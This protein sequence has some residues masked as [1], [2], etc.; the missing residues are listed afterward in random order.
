MSYVLNTKYPQRFSA[1]S[2][3]IITKYWEKTNLHNLTSRTLNFASPKWDRTRCPEKEASLVGLSDPL[4]N[5]KYIL[6][7]ETIKEANK[8]PDLLFEFV[9]FPNNQDTSA[10]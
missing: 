6:R 8:D 9:K 10:V 3:T 1:Q 5:Y 4:H 7:H 2:T